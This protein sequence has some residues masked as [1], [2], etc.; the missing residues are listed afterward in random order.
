MAIKYNTTKTKTKTK[1]KKDFTML[2]TTLPSL[3][4]QS[5]SSREVDNDS[6]FT[7]LGS[8]KTPLLENSKKAPTAFQSSV[9]ITDSF[10][11]VTNEKTNKRS[12]ASACQIPTISP[13]ETRSINHNFYSFLNSLDSYDDLQIHH[14]QSAIKTI[15]S[16]RGFE[17]PASPAGKLF[18]IEWKIMCDESVNYLNW[19][20]TYPVEKYPKDFIKIFKKKEKLKIKKHKEFLK[21]VKKDDLNSNTKSKKTLIK[22]SNYKQQVFYPAYK[23]LRNEQYSQV[24]KINSHRIASY[25][26]FDKI[27]NIVGRGEVIDVIGRLDEWASTYLSHRR[28]KLH[29]ILPNGID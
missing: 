19:I 14:I 29:N 7:S 28:W 6:T 11:Q 21:F 20:V 2:T 17:I 27:K 23:E 3:D 13:A 5:V 24:I 4:T 1:I 22:F 15:N 9:K 25:A 26:A 12:E 16:L 18:N 8:E 10:K